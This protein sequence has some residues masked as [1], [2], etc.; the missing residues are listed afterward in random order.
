MFRSGVKSL[1]V[2]LEARADPNQPLQPTFGSSWWKV[3][4]VLSLRHRVRSSRLSSL[5]YNH[6]GA[7]PLMFSILAENYEAA[8]LLV[9][10]GARPEIRSARNKTAHDL[11]RDICAPSSVVQILQGELVVNMF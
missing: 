8:A 10:S 6:A 5:A 3:L 4:Q 2:L 1:S 11:A 7:T 9:T